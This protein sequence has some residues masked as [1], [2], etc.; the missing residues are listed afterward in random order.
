MMKYFKKYIQVSRLTL[1]AIC[2]F[3]PAISFA[4]MSGTVNLKPENPTPYSVTELS[5]MSYSINVDTAMITWTTS[6]GKI[7][8]RGPGEKKLLVRT[9]KVG[10]SS[11]IRV[12]ATTESGDS[13]EQEILITPSSVSILYESPESYTPLFYEGRSLPSEGAVIS[14]TAIPSISEG[15]V[16]LPAKAL[17]YSWYVNDSFVS[18]V[19]GFNKQK[20]KIPL[21]ILSEGTKIRVSVR[22][23]RGQIAEKTTTI[24]PHPVMP[25]LYQHNDILGANYAQMIGKRF[26]TVK[27]FTFLLE[28][29][30]VSN[31][32]KLSNSSIFTW[33]LD[34]APVTPLG[35]RL[36][37][38][39]PEADSYGVRSLSISVSNLERRLQRGDVSTDLI[40]DTR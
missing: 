1:C 26:E 38:L 2:L 15:G 17:S 12:S 18:G 39:R 16:E 5:L 35:G 13:L 30:Y 7:L 24:Y 4:Q 32:E 37:S 22:S 14:L 23:P 19:S 27:D 6:D 25:L 33:L 29:F 28:P 8:L 11:L 9:G 36:L 20:A 10:D 31:L 3:F 21:E 34:G 40:F